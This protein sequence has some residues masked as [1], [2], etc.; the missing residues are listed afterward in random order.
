MNFMSPLK[1][2]CASLRRIRPTNKKPIRDVLVLEVPCA[3]T[4]SMVAQHKT[5]HGEVE[6]KLRFPLPRTPNDDEPSREQT[7]KQLRYTNNPTSAKDQSDRAPSEG[8]LS[9]RFGRPF[10]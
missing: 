2:L 3:G 1:A 9:M 4:Q 5:G 7:Q 8:A 6:C 10:R